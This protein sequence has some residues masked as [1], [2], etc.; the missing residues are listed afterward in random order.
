MTK[1]LLIAVA[2][3][4]LSLNAAAQ[5]QQHTVAEGETVYAVARK[6][7]I[8]VAELLRL[9]PSLGD[10]NRILVG[11]K[12]NIPATT[13]A[14]NVQNNSNT[15]TQKPLG[16]YLN[17]GIKEM[18]RVQKKDNLYRIALMYNL[19]IE[20]ICA[21]NPPMTPDS[22]IKKD[23]L[24]CIP[25]SKA[26]KAEQQRQNTKPTEVAKA[27]ESTKTTT[28]PKKAVE[29]QANTKKLIKVGVLLPFKDG[30]DRASKMVE[31]YQGLL[32]AADSI[33]QQGTTVEIHALHSGSTPAEMHYLTN[34]EELKQLDVI[35]GPLD[36]AQAAPLSEFC[37]QHQIRLVMPFATTNT[38]GMNNPYVYQATTSSDYSQHRGVERA[39]E[40]FTNH[41]FV[42]LQTDAADNRGSR[43]TSELANEL[44]KRGNT[45]RYISIKADDE[46]FAATLSQVRGNVIIPN[47]A[48]LSNTTAVTK[49]L[50]SFKQNHPEYS[51]TLF[52]YP[53][54]TTY[55]Q[56]LSTSFHTLDTY[57]YTSFYR[58]QNN[59]RV[60]N[61]ETK[62]RQNYKC[63]M[64]RTF[65]RYALMGFDLGY[66]FIRGL[67]QLGAQF[68]EKQGSLSYAPLQN[69]FQFEQNNPNTAHFNRNIELIHY[70][71]AQYVEVIK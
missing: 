40:R 5:A 55:A 58:N 51:L 42:V 1:T 22:K 69:P 49:R 31:F 13:T 41:T 71:P 61:F 35:F 28:E 34:R 60:Q 62:F 4:L 37:R 32:M 27:T 3:L 48:S 39:M 20:E 50:I 63:D 68:D 36:A 59:L 46:T 30:N 65:P 56:N 67:S 17:S 70:T 12:L 54:W 14:N 24:I 8:T 64:I 57:V 11:Q 2:C 7:N 6:Y 25:F 33:K 52:G 38:Y 16:G 19:T 23:E 43:F 53:E 29:A 18:Y 44:S 47:A 21:A 15:T 10:G 66:Y 9:N 26:E 45:V